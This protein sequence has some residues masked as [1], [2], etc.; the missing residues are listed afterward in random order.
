M[1]FTPKHQDEPFQHT[2]RQQSDGE[3]CSSWADVRD[4]GK[5]LAQ[6]ATTFG[7]LQFRSASS[8]GHSQ[9]AV[10][11]LE[12]SQGVPSLA[13]TGKNASRSKRSY[14]GPEWGWRFVGRRLLLFVV[15]QVLTPPHA[16]W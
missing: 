13:L 10:T 14:K 7:S 16:G 4:L 12:P 8:G 15:V 2:R 3:A 6:S 1:V 9:H 5:R 11:V